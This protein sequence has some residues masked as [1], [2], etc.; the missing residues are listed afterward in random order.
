MNYQSEGEKLVLFLEGKIDGTNAA[1]VE[2]EILAILDE[3]KGA[4]IIFDAEKLAYI[5]S[6]GLRVLLKV[7][8]DFAKPLEVRNTSKDIYDI[9]EVTGFIDL[10][11]IKKALRQVSIEGKEIIG[12][13][14]SGEV[15]RLDP[16]TVIKV[17]HPA[18]S[19]DMM[20]SKENQKARNA[21]VAGV[22]TAIPYDIV[23]VGDRY[24]TVYELLNARELT[25][26]IAEDKEKLDEYVRMF[27]R[28]VKNMHSIEVSPEKFEPQKPASIQ[29]L[30]YL[31]SILT[32]EE[33]GKIRAIYENIPDRNTF[34]HGDCHIGNAMLQDGELMFIDLATAGMGHPI[35]D[36]TSMHSLFFDRADDPEA[37]KASPILCH[38]TQA[39]IKRIWKVFISTYL[40]TEDEEFLEKAQRQIAALSNA[41]KLFV[42]VVMPGVLSPEAF[43]ALKQSALS[44]Y[45]NGLEPICF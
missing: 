28:V 16:E 44:Y 24:G 29:A 31:A 9:F 2:K 32:Q 18:V 15:Y 41:R 43:N 11:T 34:I 12:R 38:F 37:I 7:R 17:F 13:G 19:F 22:P 39:E 10:F 1:D 35:F 30:S 6:A 36:L 5:S 3:H 23:R 4:E 25:S 8:K 14:L 45:D 27:A 26:V 21:F 20:I 40:E 42:V 33:I